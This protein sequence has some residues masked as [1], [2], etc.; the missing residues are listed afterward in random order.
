MSF[1]KSALSRSFN[2]LESSAIDS[3]LE[4]DAAE[5]TLLQGDTQSTDIDIDQPDTLEISVTE[6]EIADISYSAA[7]LGIDHFPPLPPPTSKRIREDS[8]DY[9]PQLNSTFNSPPAKK[10]R[11]IMMA[12]PEPPENPTMAVKYLVRLVPDIEDIHLFSKPHLDILN[13]SVL[14][15]QKEVKDPNIKFDFC[16][17]ERGRFKFVCPNEASRD[18]AIG[19]VPMLKNLWKEPKIKAVD[20]G[21]IPKMIRATITFDNPVPDMLEVFDYIDSRN[22]TIDTNEWR[23]YGRKPL[24]GNKTAVFIGV[25]EKSVADLKAIGQKPYFASGKIKIS[26]D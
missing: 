23:I 2:I 26:F 8:Q 3:D 7:N 4:V 5:D 12:P 21:I 20:C 11:K 1:I 6:Q 24:R 22:D 25:D 14:V 18:Y 9:L 19:I 10:I 15:A 17:P 16:K 13:K